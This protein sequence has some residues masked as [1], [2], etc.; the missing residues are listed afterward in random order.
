MAS[1]YLSFMRFDAIERA[2]AHARQ[3][4]D[5]GVNCLV[6]QEPPNVDPLVRQHTIANRIH[7]MVRGEDFNQGHAVIESYYAQSLDTVEADYYLFSFTD[8]E[9]FEILQKSDEW[10]HFDYVLAQKLLRD[11]GYD[12]SAD[13]LRSLKEKRVAELSRPEAAPV[14]PAV[15]MGL[16]SSYIVATHKKTLPDGQQVY[17]YSASNRRRAIIIFYIIAAVIAVGLLARFLRIWVGW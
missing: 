16:L 17:S 4:R 10:G 6:E 2:E 13:D 3:L 11:R 14:G 15:G 9:L 1:P 7:L 12:I 8:T 5:A